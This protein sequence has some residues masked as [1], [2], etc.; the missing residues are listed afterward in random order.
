MSKFALCAIGLIVA[1]PLLRRLITRA[2][3]TI[4]RWDQLGSN[5][6]SLARLLT[7][8]D[9][10]IVNT[11]WLV[12][13]V[14]GARWSN[15]PPIVGIVVWI[16]IR[17]YL[18]VS[19]GF[20][21]I[22]CSAVT[23]DTLD[24]MT[25]RAAQKRNWMHYYQRLQP[26]LSTFRTCLEYGLWIGIASL[27]VLQI[28]RFSHLAVWGPRLIEALVIFFLGRVFLELGSLEIEHRMLP[29]EG[30]AEVDRRRRATMT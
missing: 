3:N 16:V 22:R 14:F 13:V 7:G 28:G 26:L 29:R 2:E 23:V 9:R 4:N 17:N 27:V 5:N 20:M 21:V 1:A 8:L 15:M 19:F 18:L 30:L 10:V 25:Q 6:E 12:L 11:A 24:G